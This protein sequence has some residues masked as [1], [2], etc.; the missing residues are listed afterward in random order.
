METVRISNISELKN[1]FDSL[2]KEGAI[3][4][5]ISDRSQ[6]LPKL[7]RSSVDCS[8]KEIKILR[9]FEQYYGVYSTANNCWE[10]LALAQHCGLMTRLIDFSYNPYVALLFALY[11]HN[12]NGEYEVWVIKNKDVT[13]IFDS[14]TGPFSIDEKT[15][16]L[17]LNESA[18]NSGQSYSTIL[19]NEFES[20]K[21]KKG[22]IVIRPNYRNS[23]MLMQQG[24][25]V[26]PNRI[27]K[28]AIMNKFENKAAVITIDKDIR[29]LLLEYIDTLGFNELRLMPDIDSLCY[30]INHSMTEN[31]K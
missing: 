6:M 21:K 26:V 27:S 23:R 20:L 13:T 7:I 28:E 14:I 25:F 10:F 24:L 29:N 5:G 19:H 8:S 16:T 17:S 9:K 30:E 4:R 1:I 22:I 18:F 11:N 15:G 2:M 31:K 3:F 12:E